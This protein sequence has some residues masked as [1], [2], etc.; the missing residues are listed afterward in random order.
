M[1]F[2]IN[3]ATKIY[4]NNRLLT[5]YTLG[6]VFLLA[7]LLF[8]NINYVVN[9][10][11]EMKNLTARIAVLD[12]KGKTVSKGISEKEYNALQARISF[13]NTTI[14][15][16]MYNWLSLLERLEQVVPDGIAISSIEPNQKSQELKLSGIARSFKNL[17]IFLEH[18]EDSKFFTDI[19]LMSQEDAKLS[20]TS[21]GI[22]FNLTCRVANK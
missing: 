2:K 1:I 5:I 19:Y 12:E 7:S 9:K 15:K 18:L 20:D 8:V 17:R 6:A 13:A 16:K 11:G 22:S 4:I 21:Q 10:S 14:E 3:L